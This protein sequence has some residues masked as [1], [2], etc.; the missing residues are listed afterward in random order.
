MNLCQQWNAL[1]KRVDRPEVFYTYEWS[2]AVQ[3][4]YHATLQPVVFLAYD[5]TD[6]LC[7]VAAMA[8]DAGGKRVSFLCATT[9]DY[10][11]FLSLP[12]HKA[13]LVAAVLAELRK[14]R[15]GHITLTN[16]ARL[17]RHGYRDRRSVLG[18][19]LSI[20]RANGLRVR[21]DFIGPASSVGPMTTCQC[22]QGKRWCG[23]S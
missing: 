12:E 5:E 2:L 7:G 17:F 6:C 10:C 14:Q 4:A 1:V 3:R 16:P 21:A 22:C 11:D 15:L 18:E 9:G 19:R 13:G 20:L 23:A 8:M